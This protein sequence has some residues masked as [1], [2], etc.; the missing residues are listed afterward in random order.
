[1]IRTSASESSPAAADC[2]IARPFAEVVQADAGRDQEREPPAG[3]ERLE[4]GAVLELVDGGGARADE[5][6]RALR[7]QPAVV[8][9]E[10]HD[11]GGEADAE[12]RA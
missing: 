1:M 6:R 7:R 3:R 4:P 2:P 9:D 8:V 12:Q 11:P 10:A 5:R